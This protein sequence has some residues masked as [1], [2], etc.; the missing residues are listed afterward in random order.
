VKETVGN[1][2]RESVAEAVAAVSR[3]LFANYPAKRTPSRD[4]NRD[5]A[6]R[7][8]PVVRKSIEIVMAPV[9]ALVQLVAV[10]LLTFRCAVGEVGRRVW[11][12][13]TAGWSLASGLVGV[14]MQ[15]PR[16][17]YGGLAIGTVAAVACGGGPRYLAPAVVGLTVALLAMLAIATAPFWMEESNTRSRNTST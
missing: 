15:H 2:V 10:A 8:W 7:A 13:A 17:G 9:R 11:V 16:A 14:A 1:A 12:V 5:F 3:E 4:P 6:N